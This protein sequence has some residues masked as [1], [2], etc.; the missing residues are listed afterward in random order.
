MHDECRGSGERGRRTDL[1]C[2]VPTVSRREI[3]LPMLNLSMIKSRRSRNRSRRIRPSAMPTFRQAD[4]S[5]PNDIALFRNLTNLIRSG[6]GD[7]VQ[8]IV[9]LPS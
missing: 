6:R 1:D 4:T 9:Q 2:G 8:P 7:A 3:P 5:Q